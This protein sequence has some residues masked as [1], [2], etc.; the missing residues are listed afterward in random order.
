MQVP[1]SVSH[2]V[3]SNHVRGSAPPADV[4]VSQWRGSIFWFAF[5]LVLAGLTA[6]L[7]IPHRDPRRIVTDALVTLGFAFLAWKLRGVTAG[8]AAAGFLAT[9]TLFLASGPAMFAAVFSVFVLAF[10]ATRVGRRQKQELRIAERDSGRDASQVLANI[11]CAAL[12]AALA[13]LTAWRA[14]LLAGSIA[15]LAEA[16]SDTVSSE[17]GKALADAAR[18]ITSWKSVPAGTDGAISLPGTVLGT[19]AAGI[20]ACEAIVT[21][22]LNVKSALIA[23]VAGIAG[24]FL[25]SV[26]GAALERRGWLTN[27]AVNLFSTAFAGTIAL[28]LVL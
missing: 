16:A 17:T 1:P 7:L 26:L 2:H 19:L 20:I 21:G 12:F 5:A 13:Q 6:A 27:N 22:I 10:A 24:M 25:D 4:R 9:L 8:G 11:G 14:A 18:V 15:A 23:L 28:I 3:N